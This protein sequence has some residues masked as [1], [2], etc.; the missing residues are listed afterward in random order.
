VVFG[1]FPAEL[2]PET[3][4]NGSCS[5]NGVERI[6]NQPRKPILMPFR[7][8]FLFDHQN[9]GIEV[10]CVLDPATKTSD[11]PPPGSSPPGSP[12][13]RTGQGGL[14]SRPSRDWGG[15]AR[16]DPTSRHPREGPWTCLTV[17]LI[18]CFFVEFWPARE[19]F[20]MARGL[21]FW[22]LVVDSGPRGGAFEGILGPPK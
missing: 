20:G 13:H 22:A 10:A 12:E 9:L 3:P 18:F 17:R 2:C 15:V 5:K 21:R 16:P 6:Y 7:S 4:L 19:S 14:L 11:Y 1:R 8:G